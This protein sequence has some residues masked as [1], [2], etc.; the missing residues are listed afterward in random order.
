MFRKKKFEL[1]FENYYYYKEKNHP[2]LFQCWFLMI[3]SD[4]S[5]FMNLNDFDLVLQLQSLKIA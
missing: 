5:F 3:V 2:S 4:S 1:S